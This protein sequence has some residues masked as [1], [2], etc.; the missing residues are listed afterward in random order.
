MAL[1]VATENR[2]SMMDQL[3]MG[4]MLMIIK[5]DLVYKYGLMGPNTPATGF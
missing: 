2:L 5:T 1:K 4:T 3:M